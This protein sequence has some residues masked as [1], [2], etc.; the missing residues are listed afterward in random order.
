MAALVPDSMLHFHG[1]YM[2]IKGLKTTLP[3]SRISAS[4][5]R[6]VDQMAK[7]FYILI[8]AW[9]KLSCLVPSYTIF[10]LEGNKN[11]E[12]LGYN[13][14]PLGSLSTAL[15]TRPCLLGPSH[16]YL[17]LEKYSNFSNLKIFGVFI[18]GDFFR[19]QAFRLKGT[20]NRSPCHESEA[21]TQQQ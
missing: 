17:V 4:I 13:L 11:S 10:H 9:T 16:D 5:Y 7:C 20:A 18:F 1:K 8:I 12:E 14:V 3:S 6:Y 19:A 2:K 15:T 21:K